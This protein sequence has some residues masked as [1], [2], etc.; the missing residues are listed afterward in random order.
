VFAGN[1]MD[2][3]QLSLLYFQQEGMDHRLDPRALTVL[4]LLMAEGAPR[5]KGLVTRLGANLLAEPTS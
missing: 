3:G 1:E 5:D 4:T 2:E